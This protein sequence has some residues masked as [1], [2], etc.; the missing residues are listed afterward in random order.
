MYLKLQNYKFYFLFF[1]VLL[2]SGICLP[3][4][5]LAGPVEVEIIE[6]EAI[7]GESLSFAL[8]FSL[9]NENE[10][11]DVSNVKYKGTALPYEVRSQSSSSSHAPL[12]AR[13]Y[14]W[15]KC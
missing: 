11:I 4:K 14:N 7:V 6:K 10:S 13:L 15:Q 9:K 5:A 2:F 8:K 3:G 1:F 12:S